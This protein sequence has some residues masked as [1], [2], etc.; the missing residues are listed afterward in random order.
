MED[1]FANLPLPINAGESQSDGHV[2]YR[3]PPLLYT[4]KYL[5]MFTSH[6]SSVSEDAIPKT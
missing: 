4:G 3:L 1:R 2:V 5:W 6:S